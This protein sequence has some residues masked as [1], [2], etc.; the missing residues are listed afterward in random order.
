MKQ[1]FKSNEFDR[2]KK[3]KNHIIFICDHASNHI[4][5]NFFNLGLTK[6]DIVSHIAWDIG[7]KNLTIYLAEKLKQSY[8]LSDFSRLLIDPNRK[9]NSK[10]LIVKNSFNV[11]ISG[12][13]RIN[14]SLKKK[15]IE[16]FY[17][18]YHCNLWKLIEKKKK[19]IEPLNLFLFIVLQKSLR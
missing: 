5:K 12:N 16:T 8:F 4:P 3:H 18:P 19:L 14:N 13:A 10:D 9:L 6:K 7:A 11:H 15:R 2:I 1:V 17:K